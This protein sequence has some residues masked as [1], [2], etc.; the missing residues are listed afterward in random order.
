VESTLSI[1][2]TLVSTQF[3]A[4]YDAITDMLDNLEVPREVVV[5]MVS[6]GGGGGLADTA[7]KDTAEVDASYAGMATGVSASTGRMADDT[8]QHMSMASNALGGVSRDSENMAK[9]T[10]GSMKDVG[11]SVGGIGG[12]LGQMLPIMAT[13]GFG[14]IIYGSMNTAVAIKNFQEQTG[15][16]IAMAKQWVTV[17]STM[18]VAPR[19]LTMTL[20]SVDTMLLSVTDAQKANSAASQAEASVTDA[21]TQAKENLLIKQ[22]DLTNALDKYGNSTT[23]AA[24]AD[25]AVQ[26]AEE[27]VTK[28]EDK[29]ATSRATVLGL[30]T[31][32]SQ[33]VQDLGI[34]L[35]G[36]NGQTITSTGLILEL[37]NAYDTATNKADATA[38]ITSIL[39]GRGVAMLPLIEQ[40]GPAL[41]ALLTASSNATAG[42]TQNSVNA[43]DQM[44]KNVGTIVASVKTTLTG[45]AVD[46]EP[47]FTY[48]TN[49]IG[50]VE[51]LVGAIGGLYLV[52]GGFKLGENILNTLKG[53]VSTG[54]NAAKWILNIG[55]DAEKNPDDGGLT[56]AASSAFIQKVFVTN[57]GANGLGG[58][59]L[60]TGPKTTST[61]ETDTE[62][63]LE[64]GGPFA[65]VF[66]AFKIGIGTLVDVG[67]PIVAGAVLL[68]G[69]LDGFR[70]LIVGH[71]TKTPGAGAG[72]GGAGS[73]RGGGDI[74]DID[75]GNATSILN[76][77]TQSIQAI[78]VSASQA[79]E[80]WNTIDMLTHSGAQQWDMF[81]SQEKGYLTNTLQS[82]SNVQAAT[83]DLA[84][85]TKAGVVT[86]ATSLT[87]WEDGWNSIEL[88]TG[89]NAGWAEQLATNMELAHDNAVT[90][91]PAFIKAFNTLVNQGMN[92]GAITAVDIAN[93]L[94][95][96]KANAALANQ[97]I[98]TIN[99]AA[100]Q[101]AQTNRLSLPH[102]G[103]PTATKKLAGGGMITE[104]I[105]GIGQNTGTSYLLGEAGDEMV[106]PL[107]GG[108]GGGSGAA[109]GM[110]YVDLRG[111][112]VFKTSDLTY[113]VNLIG[114][115]IAQKMLPQAGVQMQF[116]R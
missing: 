1:L 33:A 67:T 23:K 76:L 15:A 40:G 109:G 47:F 71:P 78:Q 53:I 69:I 115:Q 20:K 93:E 12:M 39:G 19:A 58:G 85:L 91:V 72:G 97:S 8:E 7:A 113:L 49:N 24:S 70:N 60:P 89:E 51:A 37:A 95:L 38:D 68:A 100:T 56:G 9:D 42:M 6:E 27:A 16:S 80:Q 83:D 62:D 87:K 82:G 116:K 57:M 92:P 75:S 114:Q 31:K 43:L 65:A 18:D 48:L 4:E 105:F 11:E 54:T 13:I 14:A 86:N 45:F 61:L 36:A 41:Q 63:T 35:T 64:T 50:V 22:A 107:T 74:S 102:G 110:I 46:L 17:A 26:Q 44:H 21:V 79:A 101:F 88:G 103:T 94:A 52:K 108:G 111:T 99:A 30:T 84:R 59:N 29:L 106:T 96:A 66:A 32:Q 90:N 5:T 25:E 98:A 104:P 34:K 10:E 55:S 81:F 2:L 28:A 73:G 3:K 112:Q 77:P